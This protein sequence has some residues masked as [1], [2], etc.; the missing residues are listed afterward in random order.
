VYTFGAHA[1]EVDVDEGTG[2]VEVRRAWCA[3][4]VGR[5]INPASCESQIQG[6]FV[7]GLGYALTEA[8][9]WNAEGWLT[10][11]TLAD[12]KIPGVL[13]APPEIHAIVLED[14]D[15]SHP[16][17]AKGSASRRWSASRRRSRM[18]SA[19]RSA[20]GAHSADDARARP[21]RHGPRLMKQADYPPQEPLSPAGTAY[22]DECWRRGEGIDGAEFAVGADPYQ[23][24]LVFRAPR[25]DG[26]VLL[27]WHGGGWTSG[28]KEWMSFMAPAFTAQG[29]TFVSAGYRLAPQH[30][31]PAGIDDA[32][33]R[34]RLGTR[35]HRRARRRSGRSSSS[36]VIRPVATTPRC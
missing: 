2:A 33:G 16:V 18:R 36:A 31:F 15:P 6:G 29:V 26:R 8:M 17:G 21:R 10:T 22:G 7:Q 28:Y 3:H 34:D 9:H 25:P 13:D 27:F 19:A 23:R 4:D 14:P 12:Y 1:V 11:V 35:E 20:R 5:A 30:V 24:L 32:A